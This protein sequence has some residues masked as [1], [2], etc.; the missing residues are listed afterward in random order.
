MTND[1]SLTLVDSSLSD[2]CPLP[3]APPIDTVDGVSERFF[4]ITSGEEKIAYIPLNQLL[5]IEA[6]RV[7]EYF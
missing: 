3:N 6:I 1:K 7:E 2:L 5:R 4:E